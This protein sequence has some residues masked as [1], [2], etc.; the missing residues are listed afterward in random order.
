MNNMDNQLTQSSSREPIQETL[1]SL[2]GD[3]F[4][5]VSEIEARLKIQ[6]PEPAD[7]TGSDAPLSLIMQGLRSSRSKLQNI[8]GE[9]GKI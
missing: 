4:N 6:I 8:L 1:N 7:K 5:L 9:L 2:S 3:V